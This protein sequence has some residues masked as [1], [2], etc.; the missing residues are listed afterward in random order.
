MEFAQNL[1]LAH[2]KL[3]MDNSAKHKANRTEIVGGLVHVTEILLKMVLNTM[4]S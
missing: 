4:Q 3:Q 1:R 2:L